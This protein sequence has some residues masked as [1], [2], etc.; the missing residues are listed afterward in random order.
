M[1]VTENNMTQFQSAVRQVFLLST[2]FLNTAYCYRYL[3]NHQ[4]LASGT[5]LVRKKRAG[6]VPALCVFGQSQSKVLCRSPGRPLALCMKIF[7]ERRY[8]G[9]EKKPIGKSSVWGIFYLKT[10]HFQALGQHGKN[11]EHLLV[12][13]R[14]RSSAII[15]SVCLLSRN[16]WTGQVY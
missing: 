2:K 10:L 12:R 1:T 3:L 5:R 16:T 15:A 14:Y 8:E 13:R 6:K 7:L 9:K 11:C 4:S